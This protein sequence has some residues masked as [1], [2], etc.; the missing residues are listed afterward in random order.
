MRKKPVFV[1]GVSAE[2]RVRIQG[3]D[4]AGQMRLEASYLIME[5]VE[6]YDRAF[7]QVWGASDHVSLRHLEVHNRPGK[8][9][10][11]GTAIFTGS[12]ATDIVVYKNHI[13]H[14]ERFK[15]RDGRRMPY[16]C[17]GIG[18]GSG[19]ERIWILNNHVHHNSGDAFQASHLAKVPPRFVYVGGNVFHEDRENGVDL[20]TIHDVVVSQNTLYGYE[21]SASSSGDAIVVGSNGCTPDKGFGP[22]NAWIL[23]NDIKDS[24]TGIRVEGVYHGWIMGNYI[25]DIRGSGITLDIDPDSIRL[26]I[27]GNT[28]ASVREGIHHHWRSGIKQVSIENNLI[29]DFSL[30]ALALGSEV[31][32]V[33]TLRNNLFWAG[34]KSIPFIDNLNTSDP[35]DTFEHRTFYASTGKQVVGAWNNRGIR[36]TG[37]G[38]IVADPALIDKKSYPALKKGSAAIDKT[39]P[40][41]E[42]DSFHIMYGLDIRRDITG[43]PRPEDDAWD[44]GAFE[45]RTAQPAGVQE[46]TKK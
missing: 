43:H 2:K 12:G 11:S 33:T 21:S 10:A 5:N 36:L 17:H 9:G 19:N 37:R 39:A 35:R 18:A 7:P 24:Q 1:R 25:H 34:G 6:F 15:L 4:K 23:F 38:N 22:D 8:G 3:G 30:S 42:F 16:D 29:A 44:L 41:G 13:H 26:A 46:G 27:V 45:Y 32:H 31:G 28:I 14:N 40:S 20:K